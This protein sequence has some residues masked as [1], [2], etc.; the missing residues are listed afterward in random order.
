MYPNL[1]ESSPFKNTIL[2]QKI[3]LNNK[4]I[5]YKDYLKSKN[6]NSSFFKM[7]IDYTIM[8]PLNLISIIRDK[9]SSMLNNEIDEIDE[10][11]NQEY[12]VLSQN[13]YR[14]QK[15]L[16]NKIS[17]EVNEKDGYITLS[18]TDESPHVAA[19]IAKKSEEVLQQSIINY[20]IKN[21]KSVYDFTV[22][23]LDDSKRTFYLLQDKLA[24]FKDKIKILKQIYF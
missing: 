15:I 4:D 16:D 8:L 5:L 10:M 21:I 18:V 11:E 7:I 20:K 1:I 19:Q 23:Q 22:K 12:I 6:N 24:K 13:D 17:L 14:L 3:K 2:N 9:A